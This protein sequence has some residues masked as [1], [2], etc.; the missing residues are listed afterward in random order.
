MG[1]L[2][3]RRVAALETAL[4][5][6]TRLRRS[7]TE[8]GKDPL[9]VKIGPFACVPKIEIVKYDEMINQLRKELQ[10]VKDDTAS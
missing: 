5:A 7:F 2:Q 8:M 10:D 1:T 6:A 4:R 3:D 9:W